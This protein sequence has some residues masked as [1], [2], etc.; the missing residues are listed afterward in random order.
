MLFEI[1]I[2]L[3]NADL[4][5]VSTAKEIPRCKSGDNE[6]LPKVITQILREHKGG[7]AEMNLPPFEPLHIPQINIIQGNESTIAIK[8][9]FK[10][11]NL[12]GISNAV[13]NKTV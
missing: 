11:C 5:S 8:L 3:T 10:D 6:C 2:S 4:I 1:L 13:V 9:Y 12:F 7:N